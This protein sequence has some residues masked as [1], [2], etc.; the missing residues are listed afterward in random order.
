[1]KFLYPIQESEFLKSFCSFQE[2]VKSQALEWNSGS[3]IGIEIKKTLAA[4]KN[5]HSTKKTP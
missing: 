3:E 2:G 4:Y 5:L 1:V